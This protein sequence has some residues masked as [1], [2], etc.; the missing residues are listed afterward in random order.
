MRPAAGCTIASAVALALAC[1]GDDLLLPGDGAASRIAIAEGDGQSGPVGATLPDSISVLVSDATGRP[2]MGQPVAF[3]VT[4]GDGAV[5]APDTAL[6]GADGRAGAT[7]VL[8]R[9]AGTQRA[10]AELVALEGEA[11]SVVFSASAVPGS[12]AVLAL[13][14]GDNQTAPAGTALPD[15]LVVRVEDQ[16]GNPVAGASV[17]WTASGGG[18]VSSPRVTTPVNGRAAVRRTLG[19]QPGE[20]AAVA[21]ASGLDGSPM[22]F[23]HTATGGGGGGGG[24]DDDARVTIVSGDDQNGEAGSEL[25]NP[26]VIR[27]TDGEGRA[28]G[29][30]S[31]VWVVTEGG[32]FVQPVFGSTD[33]GGR[34]ST[35]WTL[36]PNP[37][38]NRVSAAVGG[39]GTVEFEARGTKRDGD[40]G[41]DDDRIVR[42]SFVVQPSDAEEDERLSPAVQVAAVNAGG[43]PVSSA[44]GEV[45]VRLGQNSEN[46]RLRGDRTRVFEGGVATFDDLKVTREGAGYTLIASGGTEVE[47]GPFR[48]VN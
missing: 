29:G 21:S 1:G 39:L 47:S 22:A 10:Q 48:I 17:T 35:R 15:S 32:G 37:G 24:G 38:R 34:A 19:P 12:A 18:S 31:V 2:V 3:V 41:G 40:G 13:V 26:L 46:A 30:A 25:P 23:T 8:G 20:Q 43:T 6:T 4:A 28:I 11:R 45:E 44:P 9:D 14:S 42:L 36:G 33:A 5:L 27:V 16:F 7:W